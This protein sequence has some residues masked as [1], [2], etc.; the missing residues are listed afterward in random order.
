MKSFG[1]VAAEVVGHAIERRVADP[2]DAPALGLPDDVGGDDRPRQA[3]AQP[4]GEATCAHGVLHEVGG[5]DERSR[6]EGGGI[7]VSGN[8]DD[9][10]RRRPEGVARDGPESDEAP[11]ANGGAATDDESI[12][13]VVYARLGQAADDVFAFEHAQVGELVQRAVVL[14]DLPHRALC[15]RVG[16]GALQDVNPQ[17]NVEIA[18]GRGEAGEPQGQLDRGFFAAGET[19]ADDPAHAC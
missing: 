12:R 14:G 10:T 11:A 5:D 8:H 2:G 13:I 6:A 9:W 19:E 7:E 15:Q 18:V 16:V 4:S 3:N 1:G 17:E